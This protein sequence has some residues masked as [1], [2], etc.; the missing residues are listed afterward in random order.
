MSLQDNRVDV[1]G[2]EEVN[3]AL[4]KVRTFNIRAAES[5]AIN[6]LLPAIA[7]KTRRDS[8]IMA[9]SWQESNQ[10]FVNT[11]SYS[12]VQEFGGTWVEPTNAISQTWDQNQEAIINA[13]NKEIDSAAAEAGFD[14]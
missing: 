11:V 8:G 4:E 6:A 5:G 1:L 3:R 14:T 12:V 9:A 13:F 7:S 2:E 10:A